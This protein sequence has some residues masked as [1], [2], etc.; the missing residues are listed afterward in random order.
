MIT[1]NVN[2]QEYHLAADP[3]ELLVWVIHEK[4][5]LTRTR[6]GCGMEMCGACTVLIDEK[7]TRSCIIKVGEAVG[8][9]IT[10]REALPDDHPL[11]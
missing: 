5:G 6:F 1:L 7:A 10:T 3:N 9:K 4:I 8:K 11:K 2:N